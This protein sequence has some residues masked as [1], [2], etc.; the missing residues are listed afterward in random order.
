MFQNLYL[1]SSFLSLVHTCLFLAANISLSAQC[2]ANQTQITVSIT[3]DNYP[4]ETTWELKNWTTGTVYASGGPYTTANNTYTQNVCI[5]NNATIG[6][7]IN[8][9]YG[10]GICCSFGNG[11]YSVGAGNTTYASGGDFDA[12]ETSLFIIEPYAKDLAI[13]NL[14]MPNLLLANTEHNITGRIMNLGT[15]FVNSFTL[16]WQANNGMV[17]SQNLSFPFPSNAITNFT[18][19]LPWTPMAG[20]HTLK[21]WASNI[22]GTADDNP[23]NDVLETTF[24]V[25]MQ[26]PIRT[27]LAE[28]F[29][30]ASCGPCAAYNPAFD[31]LMN[32]NIDHVA[33]I[34]YHTSWPGF[35]PMYQENSADA[36]SR[37]SY[38]GVGGVP[39]A[40][41]DGGQYAG[42]PANVNQSIINSLAS[43]SSGIIITVDETQTGN[44]VNIEATIEALL[45]INSNNLRVHIV[46]V[47][48]E[49]NYTSAPGSNGE[50]KFPYVMRKMLPNFNGTSI[51]AMSANSSTTVNTSYTL[52]NFV[53]AN[54]MRTIVFVQ[55]QSNGYVYQSF[56]APKIMGQNNNEQ[57]PTI[58]APEIVGCALGLDITQQN[59]TCGLSNGSATASIFGGTEPLTF[60]WSNGENS[61]SIVNLT[62]GQYEVL[63]TDANDCSTTET[64][65]ITNTQLPTLQ[66]ITIQPTCGEDNGV[67]NI[68]ANNGTPPFNYQW[69][70][71]EIGNTPNPNNLSAGTYTVLVTDDVGCTALQNINLVN[72]GTP[73]VDLSGVEPSCNEAGQIS[74]NI[75]GGTP[76]YSLQWSIGETSPN[77]NISESGTYSLFV[78]DANDCVSTQSIV[79]NSDINLPIFEVNAQ[80]V[81][82]GEE[83]SA[84]VVITGG[85][86]PYQI[87]WSN[88]QIGETAD[89]LVV[90]VL[91]QIEVTDANGCSTVS[92]FRI[93][94]FAGIEALVF[95]GINASCNDSNGSLTAIVAGGTAPFSYDWNTNANEIGNQIENLTEGTY[96]VLVTD[97]NGCTT[98]GSYEIQNLGTPHLELSAIA[99]NCNSDGTITAN[100]SGGIAPYT[101]QWNTGETSESIQIN[102]GGNYQLEVTDASG[103]MTSQ[104]IEIEANIDFPTI[105]LTISQPCGNGL[106][107]ATVSIEGGTEPYNIEW[108][109]GQI[110]FFADDLTTS[111][112]YNVLVT[113]ANG[114][115]ASKTF[116]V[117]AL[118]GIEAIE[119]ITTEA[120]CNRENGSISLQIVGGTVPF[121]Y[122]WN[123]GDMGE[124]LE[125]ITAGTYSV[126]VTDANG[127]SVNQE[128]EV[129][130]I[131]SPVIGIEVE[132]ANCNEA[133]GRVVATVSGGT[134]PYTFHWESG[135]TGSTIEDLVAGTYV[136]TIMDANDC[137]VMQTVEVK[138]EGSPNASFF[139]PFEFCIADGDL[140][141][142]P[143]QTL[144]GTFAV[145]GEPIE[146]SFWTPETVGEVTISYTVTENGCFSSE[147]QTIMLV[148]EFDSTWTTEGDRFEVC[149]SD[150]PLTILSNNT[151]GHWLTDVGAN[152]VV[153]V[154]NE[155][156]KVITFMANIGD[157]ANSQTFEVIHE[158]GGANCGTAYT[159]YIT[160]FATPK[161]PEVLTSAFE[162]CG[163]EDA[164][165]IILTG[166]PEFCSCP[167]TF[168]IYDEAGNLLKEG[169]TFN[170][171]E[172]DT[173]S[174]I[175]ELGI[176]TF[177]VASVH[178]T[179]ES[180]RVSVTIEVFEDV[181][182]NLTTT[183]SCDNESGEAVATVLSG[184]APYSFEW[185]NGAITGILTDLSPA[186]YQVLVTDINGCTV[187]AEATLEELM[188]PMLDLGEDIVQNEGE[189]VVLE[190]EVLEDVVY[191]WSNGESSSSIVVTES[192]TY[193][194][195]VITAD[196]CEATDEIEVTF[197]T[198]IA[199]IEGLND[200]LL[201]PNPANDF[202]S[203]QFDLQ[204]NIAATIEV[205]DV[206]GR[207]WF[208][209]GFQLSKVNKR[210][211][212]ATE[213]FPIGVYLVVVKSG[214]GLVMKKLLV[215]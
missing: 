58:D 79:I 136:L 210:F 147:E 161:T 165:T 116:V 105:A 209:Q 108:G 87:A 202:V 48:K 214:N 188:T 184:T 93:E 196:G 35:D 54:Q 75:S 31:A 3:T 152:V 9:V 100:I 191:L 26:V 142:V 120:T 134:A 179:C 39:T 50:K 117:E 177:E 24:N 78:T 80:T 36:N 168:N 187:E 30:N 98:N 64:I 201:Y 128:I 13:V 102:E 77:I 17:H 66:A 154:D 183:S 38:Y 40:V 158:G 81:C 51:A 96:S 29:T 132:N 103:C 125:N 144:G 122:D 124:N 60:Q 1:R 2:P 73:N 113:D 119:V 84:T 22:N 178:Q 212:I 18:H 111:V 12:S 181:T 207:Q 153:D 57:S 82:V 89:N 195:T 193:G 106:G 114:C 56:L 43:I 157:N 159:E 173:A 44:T 101:L 91:Y 65:T 49:K 215:E 118:S 8:D 175:N 190:M 55:D 19:T 186:V 83:G 71:Q 45:P 4:D 204:R 59:A 63:V 167:T 197:V 213:G 21:V 171:D 107:S 189:A 53:T 174:F 52:P 11:S 203:L 206:A 85:V 37:V 109:N 199:A 166:F 46:A 140:F 149:E 61:A 72:A 137:E 148:D 16:N 86:A 150:L 70:T 129:K 97:A 6:F 20:E 145:D 62:A 143:L 90:N 76:P 95:E 68:V 123:T 7:I 155:G 23:E 27:V 131:D 25:L 208:S 162:S 156:N 176:Y 74:A 88:G 28:H 32:S 170:N 126:L 180:Q 104:N 200:W 205:L 172:F 192:G 42:S 198:D 185:N 194:L 14:T 94:A 69:N 133:N 33:P 141:L 115:S 92:D 15:T 67:I 34:K 139:V 47:E 130:A 121:S 211:L 151:S 163:L 110:G 99:P 160:V 135:Q 41:L 112:F 5:P 146:G 138:D 127:C 182:A 10:D 164:P 169:E